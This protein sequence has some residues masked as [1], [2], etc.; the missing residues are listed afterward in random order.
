M[1]LI[2]ENCDAVF[3]E[4]QIFGRFGGVQAHWKTYSDSQVVHA[5]GAALAITF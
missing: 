3:K 1:S 2:T 5:K 4:I